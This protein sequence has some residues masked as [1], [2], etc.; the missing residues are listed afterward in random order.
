MSTSR[1]NSL[2]SDD[3]KRG[4]ESLL[5]PRSLAEKEGAASG[6]LAGGGECAINQQCGREVGPFDHV[7][8]I[9]RPHFDAGAL[10]RIYHGKQNVN[11]RHPP[12]GDSGG[13]D[14]R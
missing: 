12:G 3:A 14:A 10:G 1:S 5:S 8:M 6:L 13:G 4:F 7:T 11:R 2:Y 9:A